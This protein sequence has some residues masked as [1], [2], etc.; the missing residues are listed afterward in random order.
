MARKGRGKRG[1]TGSASN[2]SDI[3]SYTETSI[4]DIETLENNS[5]DEFYK[6]RETVDISVYSNRIQQ[7]SDSEQEVLALEGVESDISMD[8]EIDEDEKLLDRLKSFNGRS[9][10]HSISGGNSDDDDTPTT[11]KSIDAASGSWG[12]SRRAYYDGD[13]VSEEEDAKEEEREALRLQREQ[14]KTLAKDDF[15]DS[16]ENLI[17]RKR[18]QQGGEDTHLENKAI[19]VT[20]S[21]LDDTHTEQIKLDVSRMSEGEK[22]KLARNS[23]PEVV[24]LL[25]EFKTTLNELESGSA[26]SDAT[27]SNSVTQLARYLY[28]TNIAFYLALAANS[29]TMD[30]KSHPVT[31]QLALLQDIVA[32]TVPGLNGSTSNESD[33]ESSNADV[34]VEQDESVEG[35]NEEQEKPNY[36]KP[37]TS[38]KERLVPNT[39]DQDF[40]IP[41]ESY[42]QIVVPKIKTKRKRHLDDSIDTHEDFGEGVEIGEVD[43]ADKMSRKKSLKF[44]VNRIEQ[45]VSS[46]Q[47]PNRKKKLGGDDDIPMRDIK[48]SQQAA[49][50]R[51]LRLSQKDSAPFESHFGLDSDDSDV[52]D[53]PDADDQEKESEDDTQIDLEGKQLYEEMAAQ[54]KDYRD[55]R[56]A[57]FEVSHAEMDGDVDTLA[58]GSKRG[59]TW[60]ILSNKGLTPHRKKENRNPRVKKRM[61]YEQAKKKLSSVRRVAVDKSKLGHYA[62][63]ATGININRSSSIRLN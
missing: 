1:K 27:G 33:T 30:Y 35:Q 11:K 51:A 24:A 7:D 23:N 62:G 59:A 13:D 19:D 6:Q 36:K 26:M 25:K 10:L 2:G 54:Q 21:Y 8:S 29:K 50:D 39:E 16:F 5:E 43:L 44:I 40:E 56:N 34:E 52:C 46:L 3:P 22:M 41:V 12:S 55:K 57:L 20:Q 4:A 37:H 45:S 53:R 32:A 17:K 47:E 14:M 15:L 31:E 63:E 61:K 28:L 48:A 58:D 60:K 18:L 49:Q 9:A 38:L 42:S